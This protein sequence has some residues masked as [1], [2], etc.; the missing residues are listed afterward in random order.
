MPDE[1]TEAQM[2]AYTTPTGRYIVWSRFWTLVLSP[3]MDGVPGP[4]GPWDRGET[5]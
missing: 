4:L 3:E 1:E 5:G 2:V